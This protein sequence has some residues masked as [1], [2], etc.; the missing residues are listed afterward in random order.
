MSAIDDEAGDFT[1]PHPIQL[2]RDRV[3]MPVGLEII[4]GI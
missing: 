2:V 3:D 4:A 1:A